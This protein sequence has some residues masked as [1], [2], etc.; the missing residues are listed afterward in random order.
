MNSSPAQKTNQ[1]LADIVTVLLML[2]LLPIAILGLLIIRAIEAVG[3]SKAWSAFAH[4]WRG[5][6]Q[7]GQ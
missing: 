4:F 5:T 7:H 6:P 1:F 2:V 3:D